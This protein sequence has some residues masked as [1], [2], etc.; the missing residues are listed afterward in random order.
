[1]MPRWLPVVLMMLYVVTSVLGLLF[2]KW[3]FA[4]LRAPIGIGQLAALPAIPALLGLLLYGM[5]FL[6][7]I[8]VLTQLPLTFAYP[9]A[10]GLTMA[11][12]MFGG[13]LILGEGLALLRIVG[14]MLIFFGTLAIVFGG[15]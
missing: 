9:I 14:T 3:S 7:W 1:M 2:L 10:I 15:E 5:S 4:S 13:T 6:L 12:T 11:G 8:G